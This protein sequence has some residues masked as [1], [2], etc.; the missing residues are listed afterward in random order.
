M[1]PIRVASVAYFN[2]KPLI[3][4]LDDDRSIALSLA[5]PAKLI[6]GLAN[7]QSDVALLPTIDYQS[8]CGLRVIPA[9]GIGCDGP[10]LTVRLFGRIPIERVTR[11]AC[12]SESHTS[13]A[14][15]KILF[16]EA[17]HTSPAFVPLNE[18]TA[19]G[20]EALLLIGDKVIC[21]EPAGYPIQ[22]DLGEAWKG[23]TGLPFVF[24]V[25]T[26]RPVVELGDLPDRLAEARR[27]GLSR[28]RQLVAQ[29]AVPRGWPAAIALRYV[30]QYLKYDIG[31]R[32]LEAIE[33]FHRL[34]EK[35]GLLSGPRKPLIVERDT[36]TSAW[37]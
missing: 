19:A 11:V 13:V 27:V 5:V 23:L 20:D 16:A 34:A 25:W 1:T 26:A 37:V 32:Q 8:L 30:T 22:I 35:H 3:E 17:Y 7:G 29:H 15:A 6:D 28:A 36:A 4:G 2:S 31:P 21:E 10:T 14:L 33:R 24:A 9:G 12:D 18:A